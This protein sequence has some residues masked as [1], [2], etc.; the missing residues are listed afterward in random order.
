MDINTEETN[1][2]AFRGTEP[3]TSKICINNGIMRE[4]NTYNYFGYNISYEGGNY[5]NLKTVIYQNT[6]TYKSDLQTNINF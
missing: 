1:I 4:I 6:R 5:L 2:M 3:I